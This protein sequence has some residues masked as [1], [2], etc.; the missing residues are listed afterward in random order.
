VRTPTSVP[1]DYHWEDGFVDADFHALMHTA[2]SNLWK[3]QVHLKWKKDYN[4]YVTVDER[5]A[6]AFNFAR[7]GLD[8][9]T[10][11]S[12][13]RREPYLECFL[14]RPLL[15]Q[16]LT[17]RAHWNNAEGGLHIDF[18]RQP[19]DYIPEVF[20]LLAFLQAGGTQ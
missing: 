4:V 2:R 11:T 6:Y 19:N 5:P 15:Y 12:A 9:L 8:V 3:R 1:F 7:E 18:F 16:I 20:T 13:E 17:R 14:P 10:A